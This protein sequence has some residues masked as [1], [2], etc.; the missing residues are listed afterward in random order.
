MKLVHAA[1]SGILSYWQGL[2]RWP[3][4]E[5]ELEGLQAKLRNYPYWW[6]GHLRV[7]KLQIERGEIEAA[8]AASQAVL[9]LAGAEKPAWEAKWIIGRCYLAHV[10]AAK[11]KEILQPLAPINAAVLEDI[12]AAEL[13]LGDSASARET[14]SSLASEKLSPAASVVRDYLVGSKETD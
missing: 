3:S 1:V 10:E 2:Q 9:Q 13:L 4:P 8:Y 12:A 14:L 5:D 11:A 6:R 7:A